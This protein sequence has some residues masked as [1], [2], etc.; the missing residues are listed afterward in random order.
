MSHSASLQQTPKLVEGRPHSSENKSV[1]RWVVQTFRGEFL[2]DYYTD[3]GL[4]FTEDLS[5]ARLFKSVGSARSAVIVL[6]LG[7]IQRVLVDAAGCKVRIA[8]T[9]THSDF[10]FS[11]DYARSANAE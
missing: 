10:S 11:P 5:K 3:L 8:L 7:R 1:D 6:G 2:Q 4:R 9:H